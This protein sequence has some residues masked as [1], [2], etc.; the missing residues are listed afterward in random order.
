MKV[1]VTG[2]CGFVGSNLVDELI[3]RGDQVVVLDNLATGYMENLNPEATFLHADIRDDL[4]QYADLND[5]T[6]IYHIAALA[7]IQ[8]SF[9]RPHETMSVNCLGTVRVL[10]LARRNNAKVIYAGSSSAYFDPLANPYAHSKWVGEE[11]CKMYSVTYGL[12]TVIARFF[13]VYGPR[14]VHDGENAALLGIFERQKRNGEPLTITGT[15]EQRRD[16][17]HVY[18]IVAGLVAMSHGDWRGELF[19]LGRGFNYSINEVA[20]MYKPKEIQYIPA[21]PGE[22]WT[23]LADISDTKRALAWEPKH[24][25]P[26]YVNEFLRSIGE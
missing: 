9:K 13:N 12:P 1:L 14:H 3:R 21:R 7:R 6:I 22:A 17:T 2:G 26:D 25:L 5:C 11:H 10:D 19:N 20:A 8:P 15:G 4:T 23:T 16:F 18:D 24:N